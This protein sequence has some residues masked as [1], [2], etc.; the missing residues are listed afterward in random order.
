MPGR[1]SVISAGRLLLS[2]SAISIQITQLEKELGVKPFDRVGRKLV[3][4]PTGQIFLERV[5]TVLEAV[6]DA[7]ASDSMRTPEQ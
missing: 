3:L 4:E 7:V 6:D 5:H 2:T 1:P